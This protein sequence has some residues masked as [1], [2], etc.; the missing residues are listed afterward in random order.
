VGVGPLRSLLKLGSGGAPVDIAAL[1]EA[2]FLAT[3]MKSNTAA[4]ASANPDKPTII[5]G[6]Y[7]ILLM[8]IP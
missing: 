2:A 7:E 5:L 8:E 4:T 1:A 6:A 3:N